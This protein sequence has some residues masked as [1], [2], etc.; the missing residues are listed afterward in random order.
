MSKR[1]KWLGAF[2]PLLIV[3]SMLIPHQ[4]EIT[5]L[6]KEK[7]STVSTHKE[8]QSTVFINSEDK[9]GEIKKELFGVHVPAWNETVYDK[10]V[11]NH[12]LENNLDKIGLGFL[13][14]PGGNY[15][16]NFIW[17]DPNLPTEMRTDQF[18]KLA[19]RLKATAKISVNPN[20]S[21]KLAADW[22]T[23]VNKKKKAG[24]KYWEIADEPYF[25]MSAE[26]FVQKVKAFA[27]VM[28]KA[29]PS[30]KIIANVSPY[31]EAFTKK[32]INEVGE[33][34]DVYSIHSLPM[35]PSDQFSKGSPYSKNNKQ[36]YFDDLLK[37]PQKLRNDLNTVK[38]WVKEKGGKKKEFHIGSFNTVWWAPEDWT[39][40]SLPAG[41]WTADMLGTF[42]EE[43]VDAAAYW[44]LMNPFPP[45]KGDYGL[46]S[47]E[48]K[49]YVNYYPYVMYNQHFGDVLLENETDSNNLSVY[50]SKSKNGKSLYVMMINKSANENEKATINLKNF[51]ARGDGAAWILDGP[52]VADHVYDY[53]LR[54]ETVGN[55]DNE[56][57][58]TVPSYSAVALEIPREDSKASLSDTPN[59]AENKRAKASS[60]AFHTDYE[61]AQTNDF[62]ADKAI[63]GDVTTRWASKVFK[64]EEEFLQVDL[65]RT[66]NFNSIQLRWEY[67][68]EKYDIEVSDDG[69]TWKKIAD[70]S[71]ASVLKEKPQPVEDIRLPTDEQARFIKIRMI[72]RPKNS[73][74]KAGT[75]QW[76]PDAFSFWEVKVLLK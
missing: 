7:K 71:N 54:K 68:A 17:N 49:P 8:S 3:I 36:K 50:T 56:F 9:A 52:V 69:E 23:Y 1:I 30:I 43:K 66:Q 75:S 25:T 39:V 24:V 76:T 18:F 33:D 58:F 29:D 65:G 4:S 51:K 19:K 16:A 63:D 73:G 47:P 62:V 45:G 27:P 59:L 57:A 11:L 61:Y 34:I 21:P 44:A 38:S 5:I 53:G 70:Q 60:E 10:N 6:G 32:V 64:K 40:N 67:W 15:G 26:Q 14:Y 31:N 41:L 46:F 13:V 42:A 74:I 20:E 12:R 48:M 35:Q 28:K 37:T 22:I 55:L 72:G 2:L